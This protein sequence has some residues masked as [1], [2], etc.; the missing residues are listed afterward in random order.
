MVSPK[1][2]P[3]RV[4][5]LQLFASAAAT[6]ISML[7]AVLLPFIILLFVASCTFSASIFRFVF[8]ELIV[9]MVPSVLLMSLPLLPTSPLFALN[10]LF[11]LLLLL[12]LLLL[13]LPLR[14][15]S[16][17][18]LL[19]SCFL[20]LRPSSPNPSLVLGATSSPEPTLPSLVDLDFVLADGAVAAVV[21]VADFLAALMVAVVAV[22]VVKADAIWPGRWF[23]L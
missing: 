14:P 7:F 6:L 1:K 13:T 16:W 9:C 8:A 10:R 2:S 3:I 5:L 4:L 22:A 11:L 12:L 15:S 19:P 17:L 20:L 21:A 18:L 23:W